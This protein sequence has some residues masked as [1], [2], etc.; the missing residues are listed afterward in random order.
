MAAKAEAAHHALDGRQF[1]YSG[2]IDLSHPATSVARV[3]VGAN[4]VEFTSGPAWVGA[5]TADQRGITLDKSFTLQ[6]GELRVGEAVTLDRDGKPLHRVRMAVWH[7]QRHCVFTHAYNST[8]A[9]IIATMNSVTITELANGIAIAPKAAAQARFEQPATSVRY[10]PELGIV[11]A[12]VLDRRSSQI[13]PKWRGAV[14]P[15]GELFQDTMSN[16]KPF[17]IL[18]AATALV[19]IVPGPDVALGDAARLAGGLSVQATP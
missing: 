14:T 18:A 17:L 1:V 7:G 15:A 6:G 5:S 19:T 4:L 11:E 13:L 12:K 2:D 3:V 9:E 10:V 8:V 16:G